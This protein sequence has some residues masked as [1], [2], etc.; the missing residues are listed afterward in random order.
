MKVYIVDDDP[1][2]IEIM[3][4]LLDAAGHRVSSS[5]A[6]ATAIPEIV[7]FKP[8]ILL[9]DLVMAELDG[10]ELCHEL[11]E[12]KGLLAMNIVF[13]SAKTD[14]FWRERASDAGA[15]GY[16]PKPIDSDTFVET[17]EALVAQ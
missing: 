4:L 9:T 5:V 17:V 10:L 1:D 8:D 16:I 11:R 2:M 14:E 6:G 12:N 7:D 13:V 15:L 3:T